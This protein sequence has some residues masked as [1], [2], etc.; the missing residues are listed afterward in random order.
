MYFYRLLAFF[1]FFIPVSALNTKNMPL[2][3]II[4]SYIAEEINSVSPT[5]Q[6]SQ[7]KAFSLFINLNSAATRIISVAAVPSILLVAMYIL[8]ARLT[9]GAPNETEHADY[10]QLSE[11]EL[12]LCAILNQKCTAFSA[13]IAYSYEQHQREMQNFIPGPDPE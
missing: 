12:E 9:G 3:N 8:E 4:T 1:I 7:E 5:S 2:R 11:E 13:A 6:I 10:G